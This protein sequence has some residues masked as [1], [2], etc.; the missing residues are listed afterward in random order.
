MSLRIEEIMIKNVV[1]LAGKATVR[2]AVAIMD[3]HGIGCLVIVQDQIP[4][5]II[6]ERDMLKRVLFEAKDPSTTQV[7]Q[8]MSAPLVFGDPEMNVQDAVKLMTEKKIKKLPI[9]EKGRLVGMITLTDLARSI[10]YLE[11]IISK[12][13]NDTVE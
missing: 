13:H 12:M 10:A 6:T 9:M 7:F 8:I 1:T 3:E 4:V 5:G 11:H 2:D